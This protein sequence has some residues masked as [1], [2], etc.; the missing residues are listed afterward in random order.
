MAKGEI[1]LKALEAI[2]RLTYTTADF[3]EAFLSSTKSDY[4]PLRNFYLKRHKTLAEK[5]RESHQ[6]ELLKQREK[7]RIYSLISQLKKDGLISSEK[8][9]WKITLQGL[10]KKEYLQKQLAG[11]IPIKHY[12]IQESKEVVIVSFD[13]PETEKRKRNWLRESLKN[14]GCQMLHKSVWM[15]KIKIPEEFIND[16]RKY[17]LV[18]FIHMFAVTKTG[19]LKQI[20]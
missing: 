20:V 13:I 7:Q 1:L 5:I 4:R 15:G 9:R 12:P 3:I 2:E 14:V 10:R 16:L 18:P 8:D 6:S 17:R 11:I 19:T